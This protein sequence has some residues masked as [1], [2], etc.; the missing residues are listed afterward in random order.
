MLC[1]TLTKW[2]IPTTYGPLTDH[3]PT[4]YRPSN[5]HLMTTYRPLFYGAACSRLPTECVCEK[6]KNSLCTRWELSFERSHL[7]VL[8]DRSRFGSL[9]VLVKFSFGSE[10]LKQALSLLM[11]CA[12][13]NRRRPF[14]YHTKMA[15]FEYPRVLSVFS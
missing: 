12:P 5:D 7:Q 1:I 2:I 9:L 4:T 11:P 3:L 13:S 15:D 10:A 6:S 14:S 8:S